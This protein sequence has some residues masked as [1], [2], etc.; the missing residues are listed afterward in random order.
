MPSAPP[1]SIPDIEYT[2]PNHYTF[3]HDVAV[4]MLQSWKQL[5][6]SETM[7]QQTKY[8]Y[9]NPWVI[10]Y[11]LGMALAWTIIRSLVTTNVL[12]PL[13]RACTLPED[14]HKKFA[15]SAWLAIVY[16]VFQILTTYLCVYKY[17]LFSDPMK[18]CYGWNPSNEIPW[19]MCAA[20]LL[21]A[22]FY[23]HA[24]WATC[25]LDEWKKD[26]PLLLTHHAV[27]ITLMG[28]SY[29]YRYQSVGIFVLFLHDACDIILNSTK[30]LLCF[31]AKGGKWDT[32]CDPITTL[33]FAA[34]GLSWYIL[35]LHY[36]PFKLIYTTAHMSKLVYP[37]WT[38]PLYF[39]NNT[40][41]ISLLFMHIWWFTFIVQMAY[42]LITGKSKGVEDN[43]EYDGQ[44]GN[45][46]GNGTSKNGS[47]KS[48]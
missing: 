34:F 47:K 32:Y 38:P 9:F 44:N 2:H 4:S 45:A 40:L 46:V 33:G 16:T 17:Q 36:Y 39:F 31:K 8:A 42:T 23:L 26:S 21:Q 30:V 14:Q 11:M 29:A 13:G 27:T 3:V 1:P 12:K 5:N 48:N 7:L 20:Y 18:V 43:R 28:T 22:S 37:N 19:D 6:E 25:A 15:E 10:V 41:L 35:R 24:T